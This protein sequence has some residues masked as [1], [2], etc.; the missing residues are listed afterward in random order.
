MGPVAEKLSS[1]SLATFSEIAGILTAY[2]GGA[3]R[4]PDSDAR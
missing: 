4:R 3:P 1:L 2:L